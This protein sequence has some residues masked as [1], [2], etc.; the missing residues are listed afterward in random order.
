MV[1][2]VLKPGGEFRLGTDHPIYCRWALMQLA[3][4]P[5]FD[6]LATAPLDWQ[7]RPDDW[8]QT[9]YEA[10]ALREGRAPCYQIWRR[11]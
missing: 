5:D 1:A 7:V 11:V 9:R 2:R 6:W 3:R 10:K 4:S 8:P